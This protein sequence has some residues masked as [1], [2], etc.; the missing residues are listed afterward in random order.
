MRVLYLELGVERLDV[1]LD[2]LY[3]LGL[4]LADGAPDVRSHE[5]RVEPR[6]DAEHLVGVLGGA[7]LVSQSGLGLRNTI[8]K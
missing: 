4:V 8:N 1:V 5:E 7:Q 3:E 6:E 2:P